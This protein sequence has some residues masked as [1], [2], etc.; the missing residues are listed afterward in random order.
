MTYTITLDIASDMTLGELDDIITKH[1]AT[2]THYL[3]LGPGGGNPEITFT[4]ESLDHLKN[5][6]LDGY[7]DNSDLDFFLESV[8]V[9]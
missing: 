1:N 9:K 4:F 8:I 7:C 5:F 3:P 2:I 6:L